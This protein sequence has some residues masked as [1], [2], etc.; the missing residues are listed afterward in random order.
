MPGAISCGVQVVAAVGQQPV[1]APAWQNVG[2][3]TAVSL[4]GLTLKNG[5]KYLF[6]VRAIGPNG[7]SVDAESNGVT[8]H[9]PP[10]AD[11][12]LDSGT[13]AAADASADSGGQAGIDA[14]LDGGSDV[15]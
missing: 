10:G 5:A 15:R 1:S 7:P 9:F 6:A 4:S 8:V 14:S 2:S 13:E 3:I 12:G 11:G